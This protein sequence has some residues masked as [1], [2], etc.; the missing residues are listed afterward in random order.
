MADQTINTPSDL[1]AE[2]DRDT[3]QA[4]VRGWKGR[5][6]NCGEGPVLQGYLKV[7][8]TCDTCNEELFHHRADDGPAYVAILVVSKLLGSLMFPL[9]MAY[10]PEPMVFFTIFAVSATALCLYLLPRLKGAF[11]GFQWARRMHGFK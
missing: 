2:S 7:R 5:C 1:A 8:D 11:V 4:V 9:Y 3:R 6:P 10:Q